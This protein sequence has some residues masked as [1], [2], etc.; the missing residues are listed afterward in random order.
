MTAPKTGFSTE[1]AQ[2][3]ADIAVARR[4]LSLEAEALGALAS[5]VSASFSAAVDLIL[6][7][8]GRVIVSGM[9]KSGHVAR[10]LAATLASTGTP[11]QFVHPGEASHGDLG[12]ITSQDAAILMSNSGEVQELADLIEYTRRF[13]VPMV[14]IT[15]KAQSMLARNSEIGRAS[16]R[17]RV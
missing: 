5:S 6:K 12:M 17:E 7:A 15:A 10:K 8:K 9:G 11:A 4:V 1:A 16:C 2:S 3:K 14:A 13:G